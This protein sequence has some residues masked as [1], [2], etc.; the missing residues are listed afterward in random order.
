MAPL[1][2]RA[3]ED[4]VVGPGC[5][6]CPWAA[7]RPWRCSWCRAAWCAR[8]RRPAR[9]PRCELRSARRLVVRPRPCLAAA[10]GHRSPAFRSL[11][12]PPY[13][14]RLRCFVWWYVDSLSGQAPPPPTGIAVR[15]S[16]PSGALRTGGAWSAVRCT[17]LP[18]AQQFR[19][20]FSSGK[21]L[22][23]VSMH[24][25]VTCV[26]ELHA[27]FARP[28]TPPLTAQQCRT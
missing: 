1:V 7:A 22:V 6:V 2:F 21:V 3:V 27:T 4:P 19:M 15:P 5:L 12:C 25:Y 26:F 11:R 8:G 17:V 28:V 13:R 9:R 23:C 24:C 14:R 20:Q 10:L 16:G 18:A